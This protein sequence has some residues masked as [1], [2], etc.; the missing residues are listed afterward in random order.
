[1]FQSMP[2]LIQESFAHPYL[3]KKKANI[4]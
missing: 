4:S 1:M 2:T 3:S